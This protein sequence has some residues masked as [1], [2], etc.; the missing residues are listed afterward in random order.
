MESTTAAVLRMENSYIN[1]KSRTFGTP[2]Q[3]FTRRNKQNEGGN[4]Q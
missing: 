1:E 4:K 3:C 2:G